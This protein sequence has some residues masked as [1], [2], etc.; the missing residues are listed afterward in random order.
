MKAIV[1][2]LTLLAVMVILIEGKPLSIREKGR[3]VQRRVR[4]EKLKEKLISEDCEQVC[5]PMPGNS[6]SSLEC[7][8]CIAT[9]SPQLSD[10]LSAVALARSERNCS[11][12]VNVFPRPGKSGKSESKR[13]VRE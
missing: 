8:L 3:G 11:S 9:G 2:A 6:T 7:A 10:F 5:P 13:S 1:A 12:R 4:L